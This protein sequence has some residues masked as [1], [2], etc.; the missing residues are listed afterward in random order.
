MFLTQF[1]AYISNPSNSSNSSVSFNLSL[2]F[3]QSPT[4]IECLR[5]LKDNL[6]ACGFKMSQLAYPTKG[7]FAF[8]KEDYPCQWSPETVV[9]DMR[10]SSCNKITIHM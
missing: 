2:D 7:H 6:E 4:K 5:A 3:Q 8:T 1:E 9:C 10:D